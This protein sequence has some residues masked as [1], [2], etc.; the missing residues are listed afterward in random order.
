M[1]PVFDQTTI[2]TEFFDPEYIQMSPRLSFQVDIDAS[3]DNE[4]QD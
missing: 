4:V 3:C 1:N 2:K